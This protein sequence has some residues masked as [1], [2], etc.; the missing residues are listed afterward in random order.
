MWTSLR[1]DISWSDLASGL[2][3]SL[4][5]WDPARVAGRLESRWS[6]DGDGIACL[7][8]R[9]ALDLLF[10]CLELPADSEVLFS[11]VTVPDMVT[12]ARR[13]AL[14][15]IPV[16]AA[17]P[18]L[19]V[20]PEA[21]RRALSPRSRA[22]VVAHL[23]GARPDTTPF[24]DIARGAGLYVIEDCAQ[25]WCGP[26]YRGDPRADAS[27]FSFGPIKTAT[28]LGGALARIADRE[29]LKRMR[30]R[31]D[32]WP[33]ESRGGFAANVLKY[34][35]LRLITARRI[36]ALMAR[37]ARLRGINIEGL[38][39]RLTR[40]FPGG[41]L[42]A[43]I[44]RRPCGAKLALIDRRLRTYDMRRI[45]RRVER[46]RRILDCTGADRS[47]P[48]LADPR[49]SFWLC[50][51]PTR[52]PSRLVERFEERGFHASR[53]GRLEVT[54]PPEDRPEL[55]CRSAKRWL[56]AIVFVPCYPE[57]PRAAVE[58]ACAVLEGLEREIADGH[59]AGRG[60]HGALV[61]DRPPG[62]A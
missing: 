22:L 36:M 53:F 21:L 14:R 52:D 45:E 27:L 50:P 7:S 44:R 9:S 25:A 48:E 34:S 4:A 60:T 59:D 35:L 43:Q 17:G 10:S 40:G 11:A 31:Q 51:F 28:A 23:F 5:A 2:G 32:A 12:I 41:D 62:R 19:R 42:F 15:P 29:L 1:L 54:P 57:L 47:W 30:A 37:I 24:L 39:S 8:V 55:E 46:A 49:H 16:D 38:I 58:E 20:D 13:H 33:V 56:D 18:D 6:E 3:A 26:E 61:A